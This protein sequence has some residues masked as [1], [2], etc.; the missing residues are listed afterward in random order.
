M[1]RNSQSLGRTFFPVVLF[2]ST[3]FVVVFEKKKQIEILLTEWK[4][5]LHSSRE[6]ERGK[7]LDDDDTET[8]EEGIFNSS[9]FI[10]FPAFLHLLFSSPSRFLV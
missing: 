7:K 2:S 8:H 6:R 1:R 3:L 10:S 5:E 4:N 9:F